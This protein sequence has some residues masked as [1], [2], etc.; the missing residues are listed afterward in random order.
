MGQLGVGIVNKRIIKIQTFIAQGLL[1]L[2]NHALVF[3]YMYHWGI[4]LGYHKKELVVYSLFEALF[5]PAENPDR[6]NMTHHH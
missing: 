2:L 3:W 1:Y 6:P 4:K 5:E